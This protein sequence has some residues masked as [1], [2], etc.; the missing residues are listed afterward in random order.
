MF[1]CIQNNVYSYDVSAGRLNFYDVYGTQI[2]QMDLNTLVHYNRPHQLYLQDAYG[3]QSLPLATANSLGLTSAVLSGA[4]SGSNGGG[5]LDTTVEIL[6]SG[7]STYPANTLHSISVYVE[8]GT[9]DINGDTFNEGSIFTV[10]G[11]SGQNNLL[12]AFVIDNLT[13]TPRVVITTTSY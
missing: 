13:G 2:Y 10:T 4:V 7:S 11:D 1:C 9:A 3:F 5:P 12:D 8:T 6:T